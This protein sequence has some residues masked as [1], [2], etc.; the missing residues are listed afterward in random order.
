ML[1]MNVVC[2]QNF[3]GIAFWAFYCYAQNQADG[4]AVCGRR[5]RFVVFGL[6]GVACLAPG[7]Y[8]LYRNWV[9]RFFVTSASSCHDIMLPFLASASVFTLPLLHSRFSWLCR[10]IDISSKTLLRCSREPYLRLMTLKHGR[11]FIIVSCLKVC[12]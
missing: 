1:G 10:D 9:G 7:S 12:A 3:H 11:K 5:A 2:L 6:T 4:G 8:C